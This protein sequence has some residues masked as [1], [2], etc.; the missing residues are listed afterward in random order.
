M[1]LKTTALKLYLNNSPGVLTRVALVFSRCSWNID[2]LTVSPVLDDKFA[3]CSLVGSGDEGFF[4]RILGQLGKL[5]DVIHIDEVESNLISTHEMIQ[6]KVKLE[7]N[8]SL[9]KLESLTSRYLCKFIEKEPSCVTLQVIG[10]PNDL[11]NLEKNLAS[12]FDLA[13]KEKTGSAILNKF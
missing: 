6:L 9:A 7:G 11:E 1:S 3:W 10:T 12:V 13:Q 2:C 4:P 8:G 5:I